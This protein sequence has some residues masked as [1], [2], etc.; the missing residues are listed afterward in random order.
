MR[1]FLGNHADRPF[2]IHQAANDWLSVDFLD[3]W[4]GTAILNPA[5]IE[6][7]EQEWKQLLEQAA[8]TFRQE[9]TWEDGQIVR[10]DRK[11]AHRGTESGATSRSR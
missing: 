4:A 3:E 9:W 7:T 5:Q 11:G 6:C 8:G 10:Q 1:I 2:R